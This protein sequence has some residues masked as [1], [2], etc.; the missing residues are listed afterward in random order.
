MDNDIDYLINLK[1]FQKLNT[2]SKI[3]RS[4]YYIKN[5]CLN[6]IS[7][8]GSKVYDQFVACH[9]NANICKKMLFY[10]YLINSHR[11]VLSSGLIK[12]LLESLVLSHLTYCITVWGPFL[13]HT[14]LSCLQCMQNQAVRLC[15]NLII[16][17]NIIIIYIDLQYL[18]SF[19]LV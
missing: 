18:F 1:K 11:H 7:T 5:Q 13:T 10:L 14:L 17:Q 6:V 19:S 15:C 16:Y 8:S 4:S 2:T 9:H 12:M 3:I